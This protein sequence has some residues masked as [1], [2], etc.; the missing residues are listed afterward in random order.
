MRNV[1]V[2][3]YRVP[4]QKPTLFL[5]TNVRLSFPITPVWQT[6]AIFFLNIFVGPDWIVW[7]AGRGPQD[8][9]GTLVLE[10]VSGNS[11]ALSLFQSVIMSRSSAE[12]GGLLVYIYSEYSIS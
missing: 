12:V 10:N 7:L 2:D 3:Y 11:W 9:F 6:F 5:S 4:R 1:F 8:H